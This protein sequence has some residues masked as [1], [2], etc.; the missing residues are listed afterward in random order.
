MA[1]RTCWLVGA[2]V[3]LLVFQLP[4]RAELIDF[5]DAPLGSFRS[6]TLHGVRFS[7]VLC[8]DEDMNWHFDFGGAWV[9]RLE[10][11]EF[12]PGTF[13]AFKS[14]AFTP[15]GTYGALTIPTADGQYPGFLVEFPTPVRSVSVDIGGH[16][17]DYVHQ[18]RYLM[19]LDDTRGVVYEQHTSMPP[20]GSMLRIPAVLP[21]GIPSATKALIFAANTAQFPDG[22]FVYFGN[23]VYIDNLEFEPIPEPASIILLGVACV[24]LFLKSQRRRK[25]AA[26]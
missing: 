24:L 10:G 16:P 3:W 2:L 9:D 5:E 17:A 4:A 18:E 15:N 25:N 23:D 20:S 6:H 26:T 19:L 1:S 11:G 8:M 14:A 21:D 13:I 7:T 22:R 12:N